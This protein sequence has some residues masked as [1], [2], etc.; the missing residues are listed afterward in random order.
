MGCVFCEV[1]TEVSHK[2]Y[3]NMTKNIQGNNGLTRSV[4]FS[5][6][7]SPRINTALLLNFCIALGASNAVIPQLTSK[8]P[9]EQNHPNIIKI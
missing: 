3:P 6:F 4:F 2:N 9:P 8:F 5:V 7:L 1:W